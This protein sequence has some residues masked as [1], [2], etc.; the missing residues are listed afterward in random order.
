MTSDPRLQPKQ[1]LFDL[2]TCKT[3]EIFSEQYFDPSQFKWTNDSK[4]FYASDEISD[5]PENEGNGIRELYYFDISTLNYE[6]VFLDW[7]Y[8]IG[9]GIYEVTKEGIIV[10]L[11]NG[12]KM[13][14][15]YYFIKHGKWIYK[16]IRDL[17]LSHSTLLDI[18]Q[19][20]ETIVFDYSRAN[21]PPQFFFGRLC[22]GQ[23][24]HSNRLVVLDDYLNNYQMPKVEI[25]YWEG[26]GKD[27]VDGIL[28]YPLNYSPDR[29]YP[30]IVMIH[31]GPHS[32]DMDAWMMG[33]NYYPHLWVQK[34]AFVFRPNY[35]GSSNHS[36]EFI[37]S[38]K[39]HYYEFE[40]PDIV[41]GVQQL[42]RNG[43]VHPDSLGVMGWSNGAILTIALTVE[44]PEMFQVDLF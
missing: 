20:G 14:S 42:I 7:E 41:K 44:H 4:G 19:N 23:I 11:A 29:S 31:G 39:K 1:Y 18:G 38:I 9:E 36:H 21:L 22:K 3:I 33:W 13:K 26:A 2:K 15:R 24:V 35:H 6:K 17:R 40:I 30:L 5:D 34:G 37:Q 27:T 12:S 32:F 8:A 43:L 25:V 28:Y 10:Q 16:A